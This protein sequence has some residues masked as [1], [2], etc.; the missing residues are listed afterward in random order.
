MHFVGTKIGLYFPL[1]LQL[2]GIQCMVRDVTFKIL[3]L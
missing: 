1:I 3:F 2:I